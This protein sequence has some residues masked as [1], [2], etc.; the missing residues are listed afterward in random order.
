MMG[1]R[2]F[3]RVFAERVAVSADTAMSKY[4]LFSLRGHRELE[5]RFDLEIQDLLIQ[6]RA[7]FAGVPKDRIEVHKK[8]PRNWWQAFRE[9]WFPRRWLRRW[10]VQYEHLDIDRTVSWS[11][12]PHLELDATDSAH[13]EFLWM[14]GQLPTT[15][16]G[17]E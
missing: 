13:I 14:A 3:E 5:A 7:F 10:P 1:S 16:H 17:K 8:W 4:E 9:R 12:C 6:L 15:I 2:H 11:V